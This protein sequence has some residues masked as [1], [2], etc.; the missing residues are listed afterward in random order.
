MRVSL[1]I[2]IRLFLLV[3]LFNKPIEEIPGV[4]SIFREHFHRYHVQHLYGL[5]HFRVLVSEVHQPNW[6][7][8]DETQRY[9]QVDDDIAVDFIRTYL[10]QKILFPLCQNNH[11]RW[12]YYNILGF[13]NV[14]NLRNFVV[15][16]IRCKSCYARPQLL[17]QYFGASIVK[18][19]LVVRIIF[20]TDKL[21]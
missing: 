8:P 19:F 14:L 1:S 17:V 5:I 13:D 20:R 3:G 4:F 15:N 18:P 9:E 10:P 11:H 12:T 16:Q 2:I 7:V 6:K 21:T